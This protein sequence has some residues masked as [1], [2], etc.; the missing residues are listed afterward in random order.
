MTQN[1][2]LPSIRSIF[3]RLVDCKS[4]T[5]GF[6]HIVALDMPR[7]FL[8]P[9]RLYPVVTI[10]FVCNRDVI[11]CTV[12]QRLGLIASFIDYTTEAGILL[13]GNGE[14]SCT[15]AATPYCITTI[16]TKQ[17]G[18]HPATQLQACNST[19]PA[20]CSAAAAHEQ[21]FGDCK[22]SCSRPVRRLQ[23]TV[24]W[25]PKTYCLQLMALQLQP[26]LRRRT[27]S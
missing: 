5:I 3:L 22:K 27:V 10:A 9:M 20:D 4:R 13:G 14:C 7:R 16:R 15:A 1:L 6:I 11:L 2:T 18:S 26:G 12:Q 21:A 17:D 8:C 19:C 23:P 25:G 24:N